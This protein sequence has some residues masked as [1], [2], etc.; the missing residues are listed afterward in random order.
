MQPS[1]GA[2]DDDSSRDLAVVCGEAVTVGRL[3]DC[4]AKA[5]GKLLK[6]VKLF[7][8][9]RGVGILPGKKS[10]AFSLVFRAEDRT[11][12][13]ADIEPAMDRILKALETEQNAIRR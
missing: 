11:L 8:I 5:G 6:D 7:D 13:D 9:Y 12:T 2:A 4:I 10:V 1:A 3:E